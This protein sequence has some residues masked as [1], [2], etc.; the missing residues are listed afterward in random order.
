[1]VRVLQGEGWA[2]LPAEVIEQVLDNLDSKDSWN[3]RLISSNWNHVVRD[4]QCELVIP[5]DPKTLWSQSASFRQRQ[6]H[7]PR[8]RFTFKLARPFSFSKLADMLSATVT[9]VGLV[10][11][12]LVLFD[13][14]SCFTSAVISFSKPNLS[15]Y[16]AGE[17]VRM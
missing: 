16:S 7:Y 5:V 12:T 11:D 9:K 4:Y 13:C 6:A 1:M 2:D 10:N 3:S 14:S 15:N 8:T 17:A